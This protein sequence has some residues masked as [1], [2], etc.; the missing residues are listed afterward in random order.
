MNEDDTFNRLKK[1]SFEHL[2]SEFQRLKYQYMGDPKSYNIW[3]SERNRI[4]HIN[5]CT[6]REWQRENYNRIYGHIRD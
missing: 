3:T 4:A 5:G 1:S 6:V 2:E